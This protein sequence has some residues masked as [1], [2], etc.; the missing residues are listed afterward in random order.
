MDKNRPAK[1]ELVLTKPKSYSV[2]ENRDRIMS[3]TTKNCGEETYKHS[4]ISKLCA[5]YNN[6]HLPSVEDEEGENE[7]DE[8]EED[9]NDEDDDDT[10]LF[11]H[12]MVEDAAAGD[13]DDELADDPDDDVPSAQSLSKPKKDTDDKGRDKEKA[14]QEPREG[15]RKRSEGR[16]STGRHRKEHHQKAHAIRAT[17]AVPRERRE[18]GSVW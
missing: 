13:N 8:E 3:G 1:K 7:Q 12:G 17:I 18:H 11:A 2:T 16:H 6:D 14:H 4:S 10:A 5:L 15:K 9:A